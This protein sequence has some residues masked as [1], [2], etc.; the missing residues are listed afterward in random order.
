MDFKPISLGMNGETDWAKVDWIV[1]EPWPEMALIQEY[2]A[3]VRTEGSKQIIELFVENGEAKYE[4]LKRGKFGDYQ[5]RLV[6]SSYE[7]HKRRA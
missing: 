7:P 6:T 3:H 5:C 1:A 4:V 2:D